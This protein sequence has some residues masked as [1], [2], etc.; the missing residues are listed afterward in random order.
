[1]FEIIYLRV[2]ETPVSVLAASHCKLFGDTWPTFS[3]TMCKVFTFGLGLRGV[4][5]IAEAEAEFES[6]SEPESEPE[7]LRT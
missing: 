1:M 2:L 3:F 4:D 5:R 7:S 6:E